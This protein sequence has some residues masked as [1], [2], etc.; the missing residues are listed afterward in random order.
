MTEQYLNQALKM[1]RLSL[2]SSYVP[3]L[4]WEIRRLQ[5]REV[6]LIHANNMELDRRRAA[7]AKLAEAGKNVG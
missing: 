4:V 2:A 3:D 1:A 6:D 5:K 7:E